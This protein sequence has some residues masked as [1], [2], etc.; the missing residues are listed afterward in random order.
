MTNGEANGCAVVPYSED[1]EAGV[2]GCIMMDPVRGMDYCV[3]SKLTP[4]SFWC[5][6]H[7]LIFQAMLDLVDTGTPIEDLVL[8]QLLLD[9]G[10]LDRAGGTSYV[11]TIRDK[12]SNAGMI[13]H[14]VDIV[15]D[16][17]RRRRLQRLVD[18]DSDD[19]DRE[20]ASL[21]SRKAA[22]SWKT[23]RPSE[24]LEFD[25]DDDP[26]AVVGLDARGRKT[27]YLC[28][29]YGCWLIGPSGHGKS[30]LAMQ[31]AYS[32]AL[33]LPV[34]GMAPVRPLRVLVV[35]SEND[36]GDLAEETQGI[37]TALGVSSWDSV[38]VDEKV[39][40][41]TEKRKTG[42]SFCRW[43]HQ[44][45]DAHRAEI[46]FV[47]PLIHF[48][49]IDVGR[50]D[51]CTQFLR[52]GL[53]PV[54]DATGCVMIGI[55]HTG[56]PKDAKARLTNTDLDYAYSG[57]GSS[58]L[59]N[60][61]RAIK[62][63]IPHGDNRY[64]LKMVKRGKRAGATHQDGQATTSVWIRHAAAGIH[65]EQTNPPQE[66]AAVEPKES[67]EDRKG[68]RPSKVEKLMAMGLGLVIDK[69]TEP[70][71]KNELAK[72]IEAYA[73]THGVDASRNTCK[74]AIEQLVENKALNKDPEGH[75]SKA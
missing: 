34:F 64:E 66:P 5:E 35:Q 40:V 8:R 2:L 69:L 4:H 30:S 9:Q 12:A 3:E 71:S 63:L 13:D 72:R 45:I 60:W 55:H 28:R 24:L 26:N 32:W 10:A 41:L 19:I 48:G 74:S 44:R 59:T 7:Q 20:L 50:Q 17:E 75:Y 61:A 42:L 15:V 31:L 14:Y 65:W 37:L 57:L 33:G 67:K 47:D 62:V 54:L 21:L 11:L 53:D 68:G 70:V 23:H 46:A 36:V 43:L 49:G 29:G 58:D 18:A 6:N 39:Q 52:H 1:A 51:Q 27:R 25:I 22:G 38:K 16:K 56:K 73:A